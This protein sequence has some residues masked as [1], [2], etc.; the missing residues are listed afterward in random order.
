MSSQRA[1][2][3]TDART[4]QLDSAGKL[5]VFIVA[6]VEYT[7][8]MPTHVLMWASN[9]HLTTPHPPHPLPSTSSTLPSTPATH[10]SSPP[11]AQISLHFLTPSLHHPA[12]WEVLSLFLSSRSASPVL[13]P[14]QSSS[15]TLYA[16]RQPSPGVVTATHPKSQNTVT[17]AACKRTGRDGI[18]YPSC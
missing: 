16:A 12:S 13:T 6:S 7:Y 14:F 18:T 11:T 1:H 10:S 9:L 3:C 8:S 17:G 2:S 4:F 5:H 15:T